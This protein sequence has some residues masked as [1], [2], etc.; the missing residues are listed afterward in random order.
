MAFVLRP[1]RRHRGGHHRARAVRRNPEVLGTPAENIIS[2]GA[3]AYLTSQV[4]GAMSGVAAP[5]TNAIDKL[6]SGL[7]RAALSAVS[8][9]VVGWGV[10]KWRRHYGDYAR[11]GGL[12]IALN[13]GVGAF[14]P[15]FDAFAGLPAVSSKFALPAPKAEGSQQQQLQ[16]AQPTVQSQL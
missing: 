14:V 13:Q 16:P 12:A 6:K 10:G 3:G 4:A 8:A 7:G 11:L 5:I 9:A 15:G 1:V 2:V